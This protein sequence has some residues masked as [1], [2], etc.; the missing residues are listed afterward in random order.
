MAGNRRL[1]KPNV[2]GYKLT[3]NI[4]PKDAN[5]VAVNGDLNY[6]GVYLSG[7]L[8]N[9]YEGF[10]EPINGGNSY[11]TRPK[12]VRWG[13]YCLPLFAGTDYAQQSNTYFGA[14]VASTPSVNPV[15]ILGHNY[16]STQTLFTYGRA[17]SYNT[18]YPNINLSKVRSVTRV[19]YDKF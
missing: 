13:K 18:L 3:D 7:T 8:V 12:Y 10:R 11:R 4:I 5:F 15:S 16:T 1:F 14:E 2:L 6:I 19:D 17:V 9:F